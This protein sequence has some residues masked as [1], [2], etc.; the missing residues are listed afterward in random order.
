VLAGLGGVV[1]LVVGLV[2]YPP[3]A[4]FAIVEVGLPAGVLGAVLGL[5]AGSIA[6]L[7]S[8]RSSS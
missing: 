7:F 8:R 5:A 1:G 3:T 6:H 2:A 4:W